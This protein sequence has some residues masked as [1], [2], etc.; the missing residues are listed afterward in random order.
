MLP[1][2]QIT[3]DLLARRDLSCAAKCAYAAILDRFGKNGCAWPG[4]RRIAED[5]GSAPN[6]ANRAVR[7]LA[8]A[9]I[10]I[11][12]RN[13]RGQT[14]ALP[15]RDRHRL[16]DRDIPPPMN[17]SGLETSC[18]RNEDN[19]CLR[20]EDKFVAGLETSSAGFVS[21]SASTVSD[22]ETQPDPITRREEERRAALV[23]EDVA[24]PET[25]TNNDQRRLVRYERYR[26]K[27]D[28]CRARYTPEQWNWL[29]HLRRLD[30]IEDWKRDLALWESLPG[31]QKPK[32]AAFPP[33][34]RDE[35]ASGVCSGA[36][37]VK[38][39]Q[40]A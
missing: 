24:G 16:Q 26:E 30:V 1:F 37:E 20:N 6:T 9:G 4:I 12:S 25:S 5:I 15:E 7:E 33:H 8:S 40:R 39:S 31:A 3:C 38:T 36:S 18:R 14:Y 10:L 29:A 34:L 32:Y 13:A 28:A 21:S 11:V 22:P 27:V 19:G 2:V 35:S 17:V 23:R